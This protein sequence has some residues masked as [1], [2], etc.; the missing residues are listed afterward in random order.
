MG[1]YA[2][3]DVDLHPTHATNDARGVGPGRLRQDAQPATGEIT[4]DGLH[5]RWR[6]YYDTGWAGGRYCAVWLAGGPL[7]TAETLE[8]LDSAIRADAHR[9]GVR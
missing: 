2:R 9:R 7:I 6:D 4:P 8:G 3:T 5:D 1:I